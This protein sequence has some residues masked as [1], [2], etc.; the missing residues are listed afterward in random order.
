MHWQAI[1]FH[2]GLD[3]QI[4]KFLLTPAAVSQ[5]GL[6]DE[7]FVTQTGQIALQGA[8]LDL[9]IKKIEQ[10]LATN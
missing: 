5:N 9:I 1:N 10:Q 4:G 6:L 2:D 7:V 3:H 8:N